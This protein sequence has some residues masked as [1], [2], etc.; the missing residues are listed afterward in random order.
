MLYICGPSGGQ[1]PSHAVAVWGDWRCAEN[2]LAVLWVLQ[3]LLL[4]LFGIWACSVRVVSS[5]GSRS[6]GSRTRSIL[7]TP[8]TLTPVPFM[9]DIIKVVLPSAILLSAEFHGRPSPP[10]PRV[11]G[12]DAGLQNTNLDLRLFFPTLSPGVRG[13]PLNRNSFPF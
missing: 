8:T 1:Q 9:D 5:M 13:D 10:I 2:L 7:T 3:S 11:Q 6:V 4:V 12:W